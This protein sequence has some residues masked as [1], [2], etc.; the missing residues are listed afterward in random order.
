MKKFAGVM[1]VLIT[2]LQADETLNVPVLR[3]LMGH[4]LEQ[5]ADGFYVG[6]ATGEGL[7]LRREV[8]EE[9]AEE[10]IRFLD[11]RQPCIVHIASM[12]FEE[13]VALAK[14]AERSGADAISAI[15]PLFFGYD[16]EDVYQYYKALADAVGIPLIIY[17]NLSAGFQI[18]AKFAARLF[19][20]DNIT[21]IKWTSSDYSGVIRLKELTQGEMNVING[22][23][24]MLL[25]GL[26]AGADGGIGTTYNIN[27][28]KIKA[29][30]QAFA[31]GDL[32]GAIRAQREANR[33]LA[34]L[35]EHKGGIPC[36]KGILE[37]MGFAVGYG[38]F[39]MKRYGQEELEEIYRQMKAAGLEG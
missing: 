32:D 25:M 9:L 1:P 38:A 6:G 22:P 3:Q 13:A 30:Y 17:Y 37:R 20:V 8:R 26:C 21:G 2:P 5:G 16:E 11:G 28:P 7:A 12:H 31:Q 10:V 33:V 29:I 4:L 23:D 36:V 34:V 27:L 24:D 18:R 19:Q 15:P 14:H 39:P 35:Q